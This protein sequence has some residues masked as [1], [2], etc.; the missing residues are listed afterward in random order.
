M[1]DRVNA[2]A[3]FQHFLQ[4]SLSADQDSPAV[5]DAK[6]NLKDHSL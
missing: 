1:H 2:I 5:L 4:A 3:D 6:R